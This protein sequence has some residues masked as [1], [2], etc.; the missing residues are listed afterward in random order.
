M[1]KTR[2]ETGSICAAIKRSC[3][4]PRGRAVV[5]GCGAGLVC[6]FASSGA[7]DSAVCGWRVR[8]LRGE[9]VGFSVLAVAVK[10]YGVGD[11]GVA[12]EVEGAGGRGRGC[13]LAR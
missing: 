11:E 2:R 9:G 12:E 6:F 7:P 4:G 10:G 13:G 1:E 5:G 3:G 8:W